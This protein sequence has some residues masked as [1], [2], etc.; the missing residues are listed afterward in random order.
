MRALEVGGVARSVAKRLVGHRTDSM[1]ARY[2]ITTT[3]DL[4]AAVAHLHTPAPKQPE[5]AHAV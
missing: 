5:E 2:S 4:R 3:D 1:Y